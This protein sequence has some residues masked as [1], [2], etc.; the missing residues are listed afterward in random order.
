MARKW[1]SK[2]HKLLNTRP[3]YEYEYPKLAKAMS[4]DGLTLLLVTK[5][6][7]Y[8]WYVSD[9]KIPNKSVCQVW[10]LSPH[11]M[12]KFVDWL[13]IETTELVTWE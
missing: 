13:M 4:E 12:R 7:G 1:R 8:E 6:N 5:G 11:Q 10:G 2:S 3:I 9:Y